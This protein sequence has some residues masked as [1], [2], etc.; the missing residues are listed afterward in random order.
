MS[1]KRKRRNL[2]PRKI[3]IFTEGEK[4]EQ[5][6]FEAFINYFKI[7]QGQVKVI[8]RETS[9]SSPSNVINYVADFQKKIKASGATYA[10]LY[11]YWLVVDTDRWGLNLIETISDAFSRKYPVAQSNPC[12]EIWKLLHFE[13]ISKNIED[14]S[15][16][17]K[18]SINV[19][20]HGLHE[21]GDLKRIY[22]PRTKTAIDNAKLLDSEPES[23]LLNS[24]GTRV[25]DLVEL[26]LEYK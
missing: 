19:R 17:N 8:D 16:S 20:L 15:L 3:F 11:E 24:V 25:Y 5:K 1:Y 6:Y 21:G 26:L 7:P 10:H 23:R 9:A 14:P 18:T 4:D 12:F 13:D 2:I 22:F